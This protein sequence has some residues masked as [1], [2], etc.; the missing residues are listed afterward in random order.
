VKRQDATT[1]FVGGARRPSLRR[2]LS[3]EIAAYVR[4][5]GAEAKAVASLRSIVEPSFRDVAEEF[6]DRTRDFEA[7]HAVFEDEAQI[8]RLKGSLVA[9]MKRLFGGTYDEDF[10][11]Y[12]ERVGHVH[13]RIGLPQRYMFAAMNF[14]GESLS[15]VVTRR[16]TR[17]DHAAALAALR[18]LL[19][20]SLAVMLE[21]YF[22]ETLDRAQRMERNALAR[23]YASREHRYLAAID[24]S[25]LCIIGADEERIVQVINSCVE[26]EL[27]LSREEVV[28]LVAIE[29]LFRDEDVSPVLDALD[30]LKDGADSPVVIPRAALKASNGRASWMRWRIARVDDVEGL[31]FVILG[32]DV[33]VESR[34]EAQARRNERL[35]AVGTLAAG[36]A[37]EIRNPLNGALLH[38]TF[39]ERELRKE[40]FDRAEVVEAAHVVRGEIE[41]L[42]RLTREFLDFA[43]PYPL[44]LADVDL[45]EIVVRVSRLVATDAKDQCEVKVDLP[46]QPVLVRGDSAKLE[47]VVLNLARNGLEAM[48]PRGGTLTIRARKKPSGGIVEVEDD[49][50]SLQSNAP[51]FD[52][53]YSTKPSGT[54]LGLSIVHRIVTSH[55]GQIEAS[56]RHGRT[57]FQVL[58]PSV[59]KEAPES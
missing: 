17:E 29:G 39:L 14:L 34:L 42:S 5:E 46:R 37:H 9:W 15:A 48:A 33:S 31:R 52:A 50:G 54:G 44:D 1:P 36:L 27:A 38:L 12:V 56:L 26:S 7:A 58:I 57:V 3:R 4:F 45:N 41:R 22:A 25:G 10:F 11:A 40:A 55:G 24:I 32:Q 59:T 19:D 2:T 6:Y 47:Q 21:T 30:A 53:F 35:A 16:Q 18:K 51:I 13:V 23:L 20:I 8:E 49:A 43:K 28:G